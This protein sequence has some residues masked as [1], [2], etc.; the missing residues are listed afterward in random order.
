MTSIV[1][2]GAAGVVRRGTALAATSPCVRGETLCNAGGTPIGP[3]VKGYSHGVR[4]RLKGRKGGQERRPGPRRPGDDHGG[5]YCWAGHS[6]VPLNS[7]TLGTDALSAG[8]FRFRET[9]K[10]WLDTNYVGI[11]VMS[12]QLDFSLT[13]L[14]YFVESAEIGRLDAG[15]SVAIAPYL[16]PNEFRF[17]AGAVTSPGAR[18]TEGGCQW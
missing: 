14:R 16:L 11:Y 13:R 6:P 8:P 3:A 5:P 18:A 1:A 15:F 17:T 4:K 12:D 2:A 9:V 7:R 10:P